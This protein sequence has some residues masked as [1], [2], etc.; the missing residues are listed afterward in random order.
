MNCIL[1]LIYYLLFNHL[2]DEGLHYSIPGRRVLRPINTSARELFEMFSML[3]NNCI[4]M[5][6]KSNLI[7]FSF[8]SFVW[9]SVTTHSISN[10]QQLTLLTLALAADSL[11]NRTVR[12]V[13]DFHVFIREISDLF[14]FTSFNI[15]VVMLQC[16]LDL[17]RN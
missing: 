12:L 2:M 3:E 16:L 15:S 11:L 8:L 10:L 17:R 6:E 4:E 9:S 13:M 14:T 7:R 5:G 1:L